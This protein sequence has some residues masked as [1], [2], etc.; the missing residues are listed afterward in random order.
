M[1]LQ[2]LAP[3]FFAALAALAVPVLIHLIQR[4]RKEALRFPSLMFL[5]QVPYKS[6]RRRRIRHWFLFLMR[7]AA[8]I[9]LIAAFSRPFMDRSTAAVNPL[10]TSREVV[11]LLDRSYS[12]GYGTTW[13]RAIDAARAAVDALG[14]E[15]RATLVY[16][17]ASAAAAG[18]P[19]SDRIRLNAALDS[20]RVGSA[21]T[22]FGPAL[23]LA[24]GALEAS[25]RARG[26]VVLISDFQ[27]VGWDGRAREANVK[28]PP[29]TTFRPVDVGDAETS[30]V[31]VTDVTFRRQRVGG[32]ERVSATAR[33]AN[34]NDRG[35]ANL[36][37]VLELDGREVQAVEVDVAAN[38]VA[39]ATF[40]P[41][42][43]P[44][45]ETRGTVVAGEDALAADNRFH[46]VLSPDQAISV[47]VVDGGDEASSLYARRALALAE[48]PA[49]QVDRTTAGN[50]SGGAL[51]G[52]DVVVLNDAPFPSGRAGER[53]R[54]FVERGGG[55]VQALGERAG[56]NGWAGASELLPGTPGQPVDRL[57]GG[58]A[59]LGYLDYG[60]PVFEL[61]RAPRSGDF[62]AAR[63][64]RYRPVPRAD[65][66]T[67]LARY[68]DGTA[69]LIERR[70]GAG[71]ILVWASSLDT[72]WNNLPLQPVFLPFLHQ[73][74]RY[75]AGYTEQNAWLMVGQVFDVASLDTAAAAAANGPD[76]Q[77]AGGPADQ[78]QN[79]S[80]PPEGG[81]GQREGG[82]SRAAS[83]GALDDAVVQS[84]S[85][86]RVDLRAGALLGLNEQ[87]FYEIRR[88]G[89]TT[90]RLVAV[91][92]DPAESNLAKFDAGELAAAIE[93][94]GDAAAAQLGAQGTIT[95]EE[96]ERRQALWWYL[97]LIALLLLA[98]ESAV[99]N[100]LSRR[101][102]L[103]ES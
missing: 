90:D 69:A 35:V 9:L 17:D 10:D 26:E 77:T 39:A 21:A 6:V 52:R 19:T 53:L 13:Q 49:F 76:A 63:F 79:V 101:R 98:A 84:P 87:G 18:A 29:G 83:A 48:R 40:P 22:R 14:A 95:I 4:E 64:Y 2:F 56:A 28:L 97:L 85:G 72:Y 80:S 73:L 33:V 75:G 30:N 47:L 24:Q 5:R 78:P 3:I 66:V 42:T 99:A 92:L 55:V 100:R 8:L 25:D 38:D 93:S 54:E 11:V 70:V 57:D 61:F 16:F 88:P 37:V 102:R 68:D 103:A 15:D 45:R 65:S 34:R 71:R 44:D 1:P 46:F 94:D 50:L 86:R 20:V 74:T 41:I 67:V 27:R 89:E 51:A 59:A 7:C 81:A 32:R 96:R 12:M 58:G 43:L 36:R 23:Q 62:T 60:H 31:L 82:P 91:N